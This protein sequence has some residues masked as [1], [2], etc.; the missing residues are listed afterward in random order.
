MLTVPDFIFLR[1]GITADNLAGRLMG[2]IDTPL[3][4]E[5]RRQA[6]RAVPAI[7]TLRPVRV[8]ASPLIRARETAE[9][10]AAELGL[11]VELDSGLMERDWG[12]HQGHPLAEK[13]ADHPQGGETGA[14]FHA[15]ILD[16]VAR[17]VLENGT[18][19]VS[20]GGVFRALVSALGIAGDFTKVPHATPLAFR[21]AGPVAWRLEQPF[22][23]STGDEQ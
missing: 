21:R 15:R 5:G 12:I 9:I 6:R 11:P 22:D 4:D 8:V 2:Q 1:H 19:L 13:P 20:H 16:V 17:Q 10:V 3:S 23:G 7:M 14:Q 18:L